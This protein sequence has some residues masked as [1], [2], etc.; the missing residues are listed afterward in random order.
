MM[1]TWQKNVDLKTELSSFY[2]HIQVMFSGSLETQ[3]S[4]P[5]P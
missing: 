1:V 2:F 4:A 5:L 3:K